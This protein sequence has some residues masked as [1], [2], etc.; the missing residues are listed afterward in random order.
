MISDLISNCQSATPLFLYAPTSFNYDTPDCFFFAIFEAVIET[1]I[2][3]SLLIN[4]FFTAYMT[5]MRLLCVSASVDR[6]IRLLNLTEKH[7]KR[8]SLLI[9]V[10]T[11]FLLLVVIFFI[12]EFT[13]GINADWDVRLDQYWLILTFAL[14]LV[15]VV[16]TCAAAGSVLLS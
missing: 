15:T 10:L 13:D 6:G 1:A 5:I 9:G 11:P 4:R 14:S 7:H 3:F 8:N 12:V 2:T 16:V